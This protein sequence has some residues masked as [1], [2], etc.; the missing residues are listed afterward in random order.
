LDLSH[1]VLLIAAAIAV[2]IVAWSLIL[3][4]FRRQVAALQDTL[5]RSGE[6][7]VIPPG[8]G[9]YQRSIRGIVSL[10]TQGVIALTDRR[11][12]F[13]K[14]I[15]GD[16]EIPLSQVAEVSENKWFK[17]NY[18]GGRKFLILKLADGAEVAFMVR[19][20]RRWSLEIAARI[21]QG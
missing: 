21:G 10:K 4:R 2:Q 6:S 11:L 16:I 3:W 7:I 17:G 14:P 5:N 8:I 18:R 12:V 20:R 13:R 1:I 19:R 9:L 15:G